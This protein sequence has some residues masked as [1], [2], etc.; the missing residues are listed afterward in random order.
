MYQA[1]RHFTVI[2]KG[3]LEICQSPRCPIISCL[4]NSKASSEGMGRFE[5][6]RDKQIQTENDAFL[7]ERLS[8]QLKN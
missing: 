8:K 5:Y 1:R 7:D 6:G 2:K 3:I 4:W